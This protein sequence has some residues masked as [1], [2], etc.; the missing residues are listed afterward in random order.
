MGALHAQTRAAT[1]TATP[2]VLSVDMREEIVRT[3]ATV[4]DL[5]GRR[6]TKTLPI[7][8]YRPAG[9]GPFP[10]VVFNHGRAVAAMRAQQGRYRP[11]AAARYLV[12]KGFVVLVPN[13][14]GYWETYGDFDPENNGSCASPRIEP[15]S[16][17]A[18]DQVLATVEFAKT[19]PYVD[20]SRWLV[21]GQSVGGLT[22]VATVGRAPA[23]LLGGINFAGGT[24][25]EPE[26]HPGQPCAPHAI[27][28]YWGGLAKNA[29]VP[30]LWLYWENDKYWGANVP[31]TWHQA[32]VDGGGQAVLATFGPSGDDGHGGLMTDMDHWV[33]AVDA[34][35]IG[36]GFTAPAIPVRPVA[37]AFA[38]LTDATQVPVRSEFQAAYAKFLTLGVPR[39][40]AVGNKGGYGYA[41]GDYAMGRALGNCQR[42]GQK[43]ALYV[44]DQDVVWTAP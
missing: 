15:M 21:V 30:M 32:W 9:E 43:C 24:G 36:L 1:P 12:G 17:A 8:V 41:R 23:G 19:L 29:K 11:D 5:Y 25:G 22:S 35:L 26:A 27:A 4:T 16:L 28:R 7:T 10:L 42:Q 39:A 44:V 14:I 37:T 13:R 6:E 31:K 18:S 38:D 33:P 2:E 20:A 3:Q 40:F 34:F